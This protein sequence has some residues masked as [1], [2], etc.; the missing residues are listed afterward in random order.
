MKNAVVQDYQTNI[1][2]NRLRKYGMSYDEMQG[3]TY[4]E[5]LTELSLKQLTDDE[6]K[7][8]RNWF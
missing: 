6:V 7:S 4:R 8:R 5:L 3:L 1:V 2:M